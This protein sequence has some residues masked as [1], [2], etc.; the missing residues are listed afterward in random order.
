MWGSVAVTTKKCT[1]GKTTHNYFSHKT[2]EK[3]ISYKFDGYATLDLYA[4]FIGRGAR[5]AR[6][7]TCDR[8]AERHLRIRRAFN[9]NFSQSAH[10]DVDIE[11]PSAE[12][13]VIV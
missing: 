5:K 10:P 12:P 3:K 1:T 11:T 4:P 2:N 8:G 7:Q 13:R 9:P 6:S